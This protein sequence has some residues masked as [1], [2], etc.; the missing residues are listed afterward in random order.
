M[1]EPTGFTHEPVCTCGGTRTPT[2]HNVF[3]PWREW[4][5]ECQLHRADNPNAADVSA[6]P[7]GPR[8]QVLGEGGVITAA[9]LEHARTLLELAGE[10][11]DPDDCIAFV[12]AWRGLRAHE[13]AAREARVTVHVSPGFRA[14]TVHTSHPVERVTQDGAEL[15]P[16]NP[17]RTAWA[18]RDELE[19]ALVNIPPI[20]GER[21]QSILFTDAMLA[22]Y[23]EH[24]WPAFAL[25][26][27]VRVAAALREAFEEG[28]ASS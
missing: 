9:E 23:A 26:L 1:S 18:S 2:Q 19:H 14:D 28:Q 24:G 17:E 13:L 5:L 11:S 8:L 6:G 16:T 3:C 12:L 21:A 27:K 7:V 4:W 25:G 22:F 15:V 20:W 10:Q